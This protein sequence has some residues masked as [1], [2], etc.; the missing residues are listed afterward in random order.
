MMDTINTRSYNAFSTL[1]D[2]WRSLF[3]AA[4]GDGFVIIV[5]AKLCTPKER[6]DSI[7]IEL[8]FP[9]ECDGD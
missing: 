1:N 5:F 4:V 6:L 3:Y 9:A 7:W 2:Q 8:V